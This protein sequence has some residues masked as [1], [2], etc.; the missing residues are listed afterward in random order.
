LT[1]NSI[2]EGALPRRP[3]PGRLLITLNEGLA[4][5]LLEDNLPRIARSFKFG[6]EGQG[7]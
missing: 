2:R 6:H 5:L 3:C 1:G 4:Q 7:M